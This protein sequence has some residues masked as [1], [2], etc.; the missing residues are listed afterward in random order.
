MGIFRMKT[1]ATILLQ[2]VLSILSEVIGEESSKK[3]EVYACVESCKEGEQERFE[4]HCYFWSIP[5]G[6]WGDPAKKNWEESKSECDMRNGTLAAVTSI[7]VHKFLMRKVDKESRIQD[8]WFWIGGTDKEI[9]GI[10]KWADGSDWSFTQ[11]ATLPNK[12]P[13]SGSKQ[14]CLQLYH[15]THATNGWNDQYCSQSLPFICSWKICP[16][17]P[18]E[19]SIVEELQKANNQ[20]S[21]KIILLAGFG[22]GGI[23]LIVLVTVVARKC[24]QRMK[25]NKLERENNMEVD[26]NP[27]YHRDYELAEDYERQYSTSEAIDR[28]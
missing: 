25:K 26:E 9:E 23:I 21:G 28:N 24:F 5:K 4:N 12:Q 15:G 8:T 13:S 17:A 1:W 27:V 3:D 18:T 10:W 16:K 6:G 22:L 14:N 2:L 20:T 11:W 19:A 7:E